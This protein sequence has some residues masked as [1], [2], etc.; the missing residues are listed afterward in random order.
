ME[1][2]IKHFA[3][4]LLRLTKNHAPASTYPVPV[5][6]LRGLCNQVLENEQEAVEMPVLTDVE[7]SVLS[8]VKA[9]IAQGIQPT[10]RSVADRLEYDTHSSAQVVIGRLLKYGYLKR[11]NTGR[12]QLMVVSLRKE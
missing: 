5:G 12:K 9:D 11:S 4:K 7:K 8:A 10:I 1:F 6:R 2:N 3:E